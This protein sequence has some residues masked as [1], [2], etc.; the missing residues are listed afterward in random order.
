MTGM[1]PTRGDALR[2]R[3]PAVAPLSAAPSPSGSRPIPL[4]SQITGT[5]ASRHI[6]GTDGEA[7]ADGQGALVG[8]ESL[9][10]TP[11]R[12]LRG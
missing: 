3:C 12:V 11:T 5:A 1:E 10:R 2:Y 6:P 8:P 4:Q 7:P 9:G